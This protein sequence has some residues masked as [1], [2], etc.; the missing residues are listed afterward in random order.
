MIRNRLD[1]Y[2]I[3]FLNGCLMHANPKLYIYIYND[4]KLNIINQWVSLISSCAFMSLNWMVALHTHVLGDESIPPTTYLIPYCLHYIYSPNISPNIFLQATK[5]TTFQMQTN[6][7]PY[8]ISPARLGFYFLY[9]LATYTSPY[10]LCS[11][12]C[13]YYKTCPLSSHP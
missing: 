11:R 6:F 12:C 4:H 2:L 10:I 5:Y 1:N 3:P 7:S 8:S 13:W 9:E